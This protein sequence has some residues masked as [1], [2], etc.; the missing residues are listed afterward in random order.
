VIF[1][2]AALEVDT[3]GRA[4]VRDH[5]ADVLH[6]ARELNHALEAEAEPGVRHGAE[7]PQVDE[8]RLRKPSPEIAKTDSTG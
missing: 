1:C 3:A 2:W 6:P 8:N 4:W 5:V 7:A